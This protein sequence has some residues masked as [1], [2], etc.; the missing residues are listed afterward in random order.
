M[1]QPVN[2]MRTTADLLTF[3]RGLRDADGSALLDAEDLALFEQAKLRRVDVKG[4]S[5]E[6]LE[7]WLVKYK[8]APGPARRIAKAL[9]EAINGRVVATGSDE[10]RD[11]LQAWMQQPLDSVPDIAT[12]AQLIREPL[13]RPLTSALLWSPYEPPAADVMVVGP[14]CVL[15]NQQLAMVRAGVLG[16][17]RSGQTEDTLHLVADVLV[18]YVLHICAVQATGKPFKR[19]RN[20]IDRSGASVRMTRADFSVWLQNGIL[21]FKGEEKA[22]EGDL[23]VA[24]NELREK[25]ATETQLVFF[26]GLQYQLAYAMGGMRIQFFAVSVPRRGECTPL[27]GE[28]DL[29]TIVGRSECVRTVVNIARVL[30]CVE[31]RFPRCLELDSIVHKEKSCTVWITRLWA[32]KLASAYTGRHL[33]E[34]YDILL[35]NPVP[36]LVRPLQAAVFEE[37]RLLLHLWPLGLAWQPQSEKDVFQALR[38]ILRA[39]QS[40]HSLGWVHRDV[41]SENVLF[42]P[43]RKE[44]VLIDLEW[45]ERSNQPLGRFEPKTEMLPPE[46][47][48][49][50]KDIGVWTPAADLWQV[51]LLAM[52]G[53]QTNVWQM[54]RE[55]LL[56]RDPAE[57]WTTEVAIACLDEQLCE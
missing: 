45:A 49:T 24:Q 4:R 56:R 32:R 18:G 3:L 25:M 36:N 14:D 1:E 13:R 21:A 55:G 54:L 29:S 2:D 43:V 47:M 19:V 51:G 38:D 31:K 37:G 16:M 53:G 9:C 10:S 57:R 44:Y 41:R 34:L 26:G 12:L 17:L 28:L 35:L 52:R 22:S 5:A 11:I 15:H 33:V 39:L 27:T 46:L 50:M 7:E 6:E 20:A 23:H 42:D 48:G 8:V 40:L 30:V